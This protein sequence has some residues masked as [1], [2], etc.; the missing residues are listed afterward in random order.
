[1]NNIKN[2]TVEEI[3]NLAV[4]NHQENK[5]EEAQD[6]YDQILKID[7]NYA[8]AYNN[9]GTIFQNSKEYQKAIKCYEKAI[10]IIPNYSKSFP[11]DKVN[12][13]L[14]NW[15]QFEKRNPNT[16]IA[17]YQFWAKKV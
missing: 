16:F 11:D 8:Q 7:P 1:M 17:M 5:L 14:N 6:L 12:I 15:H 4:K 9:L 3:F 2:L 13:S 10:E